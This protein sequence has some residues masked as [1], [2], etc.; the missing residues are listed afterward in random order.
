MRRPDWPC[1]PDLRI[2]LRPLP[3]HWR[4]KPQTYV[5]DD[6]LRDHWQVQWLFVTVEFWG[7]RKGIPMFP[8]TEEQADA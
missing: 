8:F 6:G 4:L 7:D 3:W 5:G 1:W 2:T